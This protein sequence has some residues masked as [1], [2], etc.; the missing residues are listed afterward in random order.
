MN[1][2]RAR[3]ISPLFFLILLFSFFIIPVHADEL[4]LLTRKLSYSLGATINIYGTLTLGGNP[5]ADG[6]VAVQVDDNLGQLKYIRVLPSGNPPSPWKAR[7]VEFLSCSFQG[8]PKNSFNRGTLAYFRVTVESLDAILER[9]VTIALN[10]FD[11]VGVSFGAACASFSLDPGKQFTFFTSM[12]IPADSFIGQAICT[13]NLLTKWPKDNGYPY[14]PEELAEFTIVGGGSQATGPPELTSASPRGSF[15]LSFKL[16]NT[17]R[18][19]NYFIYASGRYSA[20][21][22]ATF[23]YFWLLTDIDRNGVVNMADLF[24]VAKAYSLS[25][26]HISEPTRPY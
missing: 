9:Q 25:L 1:L 6:L 17:A 12:P 21:A 23:D 3:A 11:P 13:A 14:C 2:T 10:L 8:S 20:R 22:S 7:I 18:L 19:G 4:A 24:I 5:V 26:I 15:N 16:P